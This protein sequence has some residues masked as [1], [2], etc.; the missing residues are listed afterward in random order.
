MNEDN[1]LNVLMVLGNGYGKLAVCQVFSKD[2]IGKSKANSLGAQASLPARSGQSAIAGTPAGK[3]ACA[4]RG[5]P[6]SRA[7]IFIISRG[8]ER[9]SLGDHLKLRF[10]I[11][12]RT[13]PHHNIEPTR[14]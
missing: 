4:P 13:R 12:H 2:V 6:Y 9:R 10:L 3:D 14:L 11:L 8:S 7:T 5:A 1:L